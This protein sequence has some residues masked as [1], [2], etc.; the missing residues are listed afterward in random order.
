MALFSRTRP[1]GKMISNIEHLSAGGQGELRALARVARRHGAKIRAVDWNFAVMLMERFCAPLPTEE[2]FDW[3]VAH[4]VLDDAEVK[5]PFDPVGREYLRDII[6]D[7]NDGDCREQTVI[8]GTGVGKTLTNIAGIAWKI[9]HH[10]TRGLMVMPATKGEGGSEMFASSRLIPCLKASR[11]VSGLMPE[12]QERL[13]MNSKKVRVNGSHFGFV[14]ANSSSQIASNRCGD[15]RMDEADKYKGRLGNE[16]GTASLV[17]ERIEGVADYQIFLNTTPTVETGLGWRNLLKSDFRRRHLPCPLCNSDY[18]HRDLLARASLSESNLKGWFTLAWSEQYCVLPAKYNFSAALSS[19]SATVENGTRI[20]MAFMAWDKEASRPDGSHDLGRVFR[21][22]RLVCPHCQGQ[23]RDEHKVWMDKNAVWVPT[24]PGSPHHKGYHLSSLYAPPLFSN[25]NS[26]LGGRALKFL[27]ARE[28][29]EGMKGFIN[30]TLAEVD[31]SQEHG[32]SAIELNSQNFAGADWTPLMACDFQKLWPYIWFV[33]QKWSSFK[34]QAPFPIT[35]GRPNFADHLDKNPALKRQCETLVAGH[36]PAW[37][38]LAEILRFDNRSGQFP[39]LAFLIEKNITGLALVQVWRERCNLNT[40]DLGRFIYREMG[41]RLPKGG[42][43]EVIAAGHVEL[44]GEDAWAELKEVQQQFGVGQPL[45]KFG[46]HPNRAVLVD[47]GYMESHNP[48]VL[49]KCYESGAFEGARFEYYDPIAKRF[50][51]F[52]MHEFCR[53]VPVDCWIP[54]KGYPIR[55][56]GRWK[57]AGIQSSTHWAAD[58]PF[59]GL[60]EGGK[61]TIAVLEAA[62]E[63]YF[64]KWMEKRGRQKEIREAIAAGKSYR[65][66]VWNVANDCKFFGNQCRSR[67]DFERQMNARGIGQ[68]GEIWERGTGGGGKRRHP[69]HLNDCAGQ[70]QEALAEVLGFFSYERAQP[71]T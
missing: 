70:M 29:G 64:R 26:L 20:P 32:S 46:L 67:E 69:D 22:A 15:I 27:N 50:T 9:V 31:V 2:P 13:F 51:K 24:Q 34:L 3:A 19:A 49:R 40:L 47:S 57:V 23:V 18:R 66:H 21:S 28:D 39:L 53:P 4:L 55:Q 52:R 37:I 8:T 12:G 38:P 43:S 59:K 42:D 30:S 58:D 56:A 25:E 7:N 10:P 17:K 41:T 60:G 68:D 44:S 45:R 35:D 16:A 65:G 6:N 36:A 63:H 62:S 48:E 61:K 33:V 1:Q 11:A 5:G 54:F 71:G 14:G